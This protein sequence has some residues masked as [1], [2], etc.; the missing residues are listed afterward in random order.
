MTDAMVYR[1][2]DDAGLLVDPPIVLGHRRRSIFDLS[3]RGRQPMA[4][5]D[6]RLWTVY[7]GEIYNHV[8]LGRELRTL[9]HEF[10]TTC[11]TEVLL[12]AF[13]QWGT[14]A[15][16]RLN[17]DFSFV[18][19]DREQQELLCVRDRFAV[20]PFY[21]TVA[22]GRFRFA[23]EIKSL[24]L[25]PDVPRRP[26]DARVLDFLARQLIDHTEETLFEGIRQLPAGS[27]MK[28][29]PSDGPGDPVIWYRPKPARLGGQRPA[30]A[31]RERLTEATRLRLRSDVPLGVALSGGLDSSS[32]MSLASKLLATEGAPPPICFSA[33]SRDPKID[34]GRWAQ[35]VIEATGARN[36]DITPND[37][38]LLGE[39]DSLLWHMDEPFHSP[40]VYGHWKVLELARSAD[41]IVVLEGQAGDDV[42]AGYHSL[43]PS[44]LYSLL[45]QGRPVRAVKELVARQR[46]HGVSVVRSLIDLAKFAMPSALRQ[47]RLPTWLRA[48][49]DIPRPPRPGRALRKQQLHSLSLMPMPGFL[50]HDD[51]NS[52]SLGVEGRS[53]FLDHNVIECG[54]ALGTGDLLRDGMTK[55]ALREAMSGIVPR[56]ILERADKQG[57]SVDQN[58]WFSRGDLGDVVEQTFTSESMASRPYFEPGQLIATLEAHRAGEDHAI[59]LWRAFIVERWH[60]VFIDPPVLEVP[61]PHP[62]SPTS[63]IRA[64]D[65]TIRLAEAKEPIP[66]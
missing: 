30:D 46:V 45:T 37:R 13:E 5:P 54:L 6:G 36:L 50:H 31:V 48:G 8:E 21:F 1:G 63:A 9:G 39:L 23:S 10:H 28:V 58:D 12:A 14:G 64:A 27:F 3:T 35:Y 60:R 51:R 11:D 40:T 15:L 43:Y 20:K 66:A 17:G 42:F 61:P 49:S 18:I 34:E 29:T 7:N 56:E 47:R 55:Q 19:W 38:E 24:L 32:V 41:I 25:D 44:F 59:E 57:F 2:P 62:S 22:A 65:N 52:M 4:S 16:D 53:P 26:N 33:R